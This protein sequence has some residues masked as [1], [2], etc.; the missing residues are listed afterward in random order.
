MLNRFLLSKK[1]RMLLILVAFLSA[2]LTIFS[3]ATPLNRKNQAIDSLGEDT[4]KQTRALALAINYYNA[5]RLE[6]LA[7]NPA[8]SP[9]YQ[10]L[11]GLLARAKESFG[12]SRVYVLYHGIGGKLGYLADADYRTNTV[13]LTD[14][15]PIASLYDEKKYPSRS[16]VEQIF[17]G[18]KKE[19][20]L[21]TILDGNLLVSYLPL[22]SSSG[23]VIAVLGVDSK[24][25]YSDFSRFGP[26]D[27]ETLTVVG[28]STFLV[29]LMLFLACL[30][31]S[32]KFDDKDDKY[33]RQKPQKA[34]KK[35]STALVD[36]LEDVNPDDYL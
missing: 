15:Q 29:S 17:D 23:K 6:S 25:H 34:S 27:F 9:F 11:C 19:S 13:P 12:F 36:K 8:E 20:F 3:V 22:F 35:D 21:P 5:P 24:L 18:K 28:A 2:V 31:R 10:N 33:K 30:D 7:G 1:T 16:L 32:K 14:Y 26:I 4:L